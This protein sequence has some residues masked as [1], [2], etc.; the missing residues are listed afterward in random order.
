MFR[1]RAPLDAIAHPF[2]RESLRRSRMGAAM[3]IATTL[4]GAG[5][6]QA[7]T[8]ET[9]VS[10]PASV[11]AA[12]AAAFLGTEWERADEETD[13]GFTWTL[14]EEAEATPGRPAFRVEARLAVP[15]PVAAE[16]LMDSLSDPTPTTSGESRRL[17][18]RTAE[19]AL[20][21]TFI[22]LPFMFSDRELAIRIEHTRD[23]TTGVHR[24]G[25]RDANEV[26]PPPSDDVLR[27]ASVGYW[28]FHP[29]DAGG[30]RAIYVTRAEVGGSLPKSIGDR[31]MRG[32][33]GDAVK[34]LHRL[35]AM[36]SDV[37]GI[38]VG[39]DP[40]ATLERLTRLVAEA[41]A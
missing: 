21:H 11:S 31:M 2:L 37:I 29:D 28:E 22:D 17:L 8:S 27:L 23:V 14:F 39:A 25:W 35:V 19:S 7:E 1:F 24:V 34:R 5:P 13:D 20:V 9:A 15:P 33:A 26:L 41:L 12:S 36:R 4:V 18:E 40:A 38:D 30:T 10:T 3:A 6:V 16:T 32:Q